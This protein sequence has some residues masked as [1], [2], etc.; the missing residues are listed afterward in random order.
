M[1]RAGLLRPSSFSQCGSRSSHHSRQNLHSC[2]TLWK[3]EAQVDDSSSMLEWFPT[4]HLPGVEQKPP[5][6]TLK[7][8][9]LKIRK[10]FSDCSELPANSLVT[11]AF[12]LQIRGSRRGTQDG[13]L[14]WKFS[15]QPR[16]LGGADP[17]TRAWQ[18]SSFCRRDSRVESIQ[19]SDVRKS[20]P[21]F[22]LYKIKIHSSARPWVCPRLYSNRSQYHCVVQN[23]QLRTFGASMR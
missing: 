3:I 13:C 4:R 12:P 11:V 17:K 16:E 5:S 20:T 9:L 1:P 23:R 10:E 2:Q 21:T 14:P 6:R 18:F 7:A 8:G 19:P 22:W 15:L